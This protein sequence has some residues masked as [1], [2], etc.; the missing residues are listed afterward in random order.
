M[1]GAGIFLLVINF[2]LGVATC[3]PGY[4][5][6]LFTKF[7]S[8]WVK[9]KNAASLKTTGGIKRRN[10]GKPQNFKVIIAFNRRDYFKKRFEEANS[11]QLYHSKAAGIANNMFMPV[12]GF[13]QARHNW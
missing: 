3:C 10:P 8:S 11:T 12:Y 13:L 6:I 7:T 1:T 4:L 2:R 5:Y 9:K